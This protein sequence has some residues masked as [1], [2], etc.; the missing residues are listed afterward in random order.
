[1]G[2]LGSAARTQLAAANEFKGG[3]GVFRLYVPRFL[4]RLAQTF[5]RIVIRQREGFQIQG[6]SRPNQFC[7][8]DGAVRRGTVRMQ[9]NKA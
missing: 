2:L 7:G 4:L 3:V 5:E 6:M 8:S 9:I 1:M